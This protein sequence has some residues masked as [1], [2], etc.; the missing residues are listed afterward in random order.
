MKV[1][2]NREQPVLLFQDKTMTDLINNEIPWKWFIFCWF[3]CEFGNFHL[4]ANQIASLSYSLLL[5]CVEM[6]LVLWY[7]TFNLRVATVSVLSSKNN[8]TVGKWIQSINVS[9]I[10]HLSQ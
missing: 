3:F 1:D 2:T 7:L 9:K 8:D 4:A 5:G 10:K 6:L